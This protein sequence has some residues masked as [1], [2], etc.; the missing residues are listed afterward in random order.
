MLSLISIFGHSLE[1]IKSIIT[2]AGIVL[3]TASFG[4][5]WV[6][7]PSSKLIKKIDSIYTSIEVNLPVLLKIKDEFSPNG[8]SSLKDAINRLEVGQQKN[9]ERHKLLISELGMSFFETD[10][11]GSCIWVSPKWENL[12]GILH[13]NAMGNGWINAIHPWDREKVYK[14]WSESIKQQRSFNMIYMVNKED[15]KKIT[16]QTVLLKDVKNNITGVIGT[17]SLLETP[18]NNGKPLYDKSGQG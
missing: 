10:A 18:D 12:T 5:R 16:C 14:E 2:I 15:P 3:T 4:W 9:T 6:W 1:D 7:V 11:K 13:E 8:G 17:I